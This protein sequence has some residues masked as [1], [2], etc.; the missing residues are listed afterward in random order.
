MGTNYDLIEGGTCPTCGNHDDARR[1][2]IGKSSGGWCFGLHVYP[3]E[4]INNLGDWLPLFRKGVIRDEYNKLRTPAE[5][6]DIIVGRASV[7]KPP[8]PEWLEEQEA[9]FDKAS[10]SLRTK[11]DGHHCIG[12]G[13]GPWDFMVGE[14]S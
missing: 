9:V 1:R 7:H 13:E 11:I 8:T 6:V 4:G 12:H 3:D 2:H 14:F 5:M 10:G